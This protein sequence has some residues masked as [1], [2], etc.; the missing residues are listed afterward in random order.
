MSKTKSFWHKDG[1][2][3]EV[4]YTSTPI[5][6]G[7]QVVGAVV[8]FRDVSEKRQAQQQLLNALKEVDTLR[9]KL[10]LE[11]AY[12]QEEI[13]SEFNHHQIVGHSPAIRSVL[14]KINLVAGTDSTVLINGES[15]TGK[16]LIARAIHDT[17]HR[18][19]RSLIRVN[20]AAIPAELFESE[21]FGHSKGAFTGATETRMGRFELA[22]GGTLF[23]DE[24]GR[25]PAGITGQVTESTA[26]TTI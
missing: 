16:E 24:V 12:L 6:D 10:E 11:N 23:L 26:R 9:K 25:N 8:I 5:K 7:E 3:I 2:A 19:G 17:S 14:E 15:G 4:E 21:F 1:H 18:S 13:S 22:D 20:C